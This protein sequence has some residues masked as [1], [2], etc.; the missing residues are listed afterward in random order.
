[1]RRRRILRED[2]QALWTAFVRGITPLARRDAATVRTPEP[3]GGPAQS[4]PATP[5]SRAPGDA[6]RARAPATE[7]DAF[8]APPGRPPGPSYTRVPSNATMEI[9]VR[10]PGI[11]DTSWRSLVS[12][13]LRPTRTL[14]LHGQNA[15]TAFLRLHAFLTQARADNTR[16]VEVITGLGSGQGGGVLRRE[17]PLWLGRS[18]LR[19]H[20]LAVVHPHA[21]NQGSV[22]I[23][24]RRPGRH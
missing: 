17:L 18:D 3:T 24:L 12:G 6:A 14:D 5:A 2:E 15:Q 19:P 9:G 4:A 10:R 22:R 21:A 23:L 1:M 8:P 13:K 7:G 20:I 16:C 11:D